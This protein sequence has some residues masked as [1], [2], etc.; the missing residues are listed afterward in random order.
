MSLTLQQYIEG[1]ENGSLDA[2]K[3]LSAYLEKAQEQRGKNTNALLTITDAYAHDHEK[4]AREKRLHAAPVIIKD[5]ILIQGIRATCGSK[6]LEDYIAPYSATVWNRLEEAG[7]VVIGK[8]N[9]DEFA[10]GSSNEYSA[11][12]PA[13]NVY[14]DNKI[15]GGTSGGSAVAVAADFCLAAL[16]TDTGGSVRQPAFMCNIVG[17]KPTYGRVSRYGVQ[18]QASSFDQ[19]GVLTKTV[20]DAAI[21]LDV[22]AGQDDHDAT[23]VAKDDHAQWFAALKKDSLKGVKIAVL[24]EFF[25]E[26]IDPLIAEQTRAMIAKAESLGATVEYMNFPLLQ[27]IV[28]TYY[29]LTPAEVSTNLA[30]FDGIRYGLQDDPTKFDSIHEYYSHVRDQ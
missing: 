28:P 24:N 2:S 15:T 1:V 17:L 27:Y 8:S 13:K 10:I 29:I 18:A 16:G 4:G 19:V 12:G 25:A 11:Y 7:A 14:G 5:N 23:S 9:M 20:G 6:I 26:G 3:I 22:I 30:R 21:M